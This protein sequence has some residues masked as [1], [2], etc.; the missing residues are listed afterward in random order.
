MAWRLSQRSCS[1]PAGSVRKTPAGPTTRS[2]RHLCGRKSQRPEV[3]A[4]PGRPLAAPGPA[5]RRGR[6]TA[7]EERC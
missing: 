2:Q 6:R 1:M 5:T 3:Q 4:R 7:V